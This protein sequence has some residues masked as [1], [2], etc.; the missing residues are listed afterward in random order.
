MGSVGFS[1]EGP[2]SCS[3]TI[4]PRAAGQGMSSAQKLEPLLAIE[5]GS[6]HQGKRIH[7]TSRVSVDLDPGFRDGQFVRSGTEMSV[8]QQ[9]LMIAL[10]LDVV[11]DHVPWISR[12]LL[13]RQNRQGCSIPRSKT[14]AYRNISP[15]PIMISPVDISAGEPGRGGSVTC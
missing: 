6:A 11:R 14:Q 1:R 8:E 7:R 10:N 13:I 2:C 12:F 3:R 5:C 15:G 4:F 9:T